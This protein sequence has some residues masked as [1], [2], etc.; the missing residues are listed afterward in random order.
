M[1]V[2][3]PATR[4][5]FAKVSIGVGWTGFRR[6]DGLRVEFGP[7]GQRPRDQEGS[8]CSLGVPS[9]GQSEQR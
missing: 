1:Q 7:A 6:A 2:G 9:S 5:F 8:D 3:L 4:V